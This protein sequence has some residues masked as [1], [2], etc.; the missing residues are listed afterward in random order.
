MSGYGQVASISGAKHSNR[1][2]KIRKARKVK[3][4]LRQRVRNWLMREEIEEDVIDTMVSEENNPDLIIG[5]IL[6]Y[7]AESGIAI[8]ELYEDV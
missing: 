5:K 8:C 1:S 7:D 6:S 4:T 2:Q 3:L